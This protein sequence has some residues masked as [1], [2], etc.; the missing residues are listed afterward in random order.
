MGCVKCRDRQIYY[1][2]RKMVIY[3][4]CRRFVSTVVVCFPWNGA[5]KRSVNRANHSFGLNDILA[6]PFSGGSAVSHHKGCS[7]ETIHANSALHEGCRG[8][9]YFVQVDGSRFKLPL[10]GSECLGMLLKCDRCRSIQKV[11]RCR[12]TSEVCTEL[13]KQ[14]GEILNVRVKVGHLCSRNNCKTINCKSININI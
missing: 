6:Q 5:D 14:L 2:E 1:F 10:M 13:L 9:W 7:T 3:L 8:G 11:K 4:W 12:V